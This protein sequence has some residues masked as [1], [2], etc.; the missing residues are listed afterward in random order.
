MQNVL[1]CT[2]TYLYVRVRVC[3]FAWASP[4]EHLCRPRRLA[5]SELPFT[6]PNVVPFALQV[7]TTRIANSQ[8]YRICLMVRLSPAISGVHVAR[9]RF[10]N[11]HI[12][13]TAVNDTF[14]HVA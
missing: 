1:V 4:S 6:R 14:M 7:Q 5:C 3:V 11:T 12:I 9:I 2:Y 13:L 8:V 10:A